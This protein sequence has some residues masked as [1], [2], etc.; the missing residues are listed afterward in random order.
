MQV[1]RF[2]KPSLLAACCIT[3]LLAGCKV[4][5]D[6]ETPAPPVAQADTWISGA[7]DAQGVIE[8]DWWKHFHDPVL[9]Q[10]IAKASAGN[11]DLKIAEARISESSARATASP[12]PA[13]RDLISPSRSTLTRAALTPHGSWTFSAEGA[14]RL[15]PQ[16]RISRRWKPRATTCA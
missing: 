16:R 2:S 9:D 15:K 6:Y 12:S 5:P 8:Q 14:V 3:A 10:L 13:H 11:W 4:G 7:T 1:T